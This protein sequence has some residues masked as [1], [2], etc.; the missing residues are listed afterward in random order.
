MEFDRE[1]ITDQRIG[2]VL[3][4]PP[5]RKN[6]GVW[7]HEAVRDAIEQLESKEVER[8]PEVERFNMRGA[9]SKGISEGGEQERELA[10]HYGKWAEVSVQWPCVNAM[11]MRISESWTLEAEQA[12][13]SAEMDA[14]RWCGRLLFIA[15]EILYAY[16]FHWDGYRNKALRPK[17]LSSR[18]K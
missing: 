12:N 2:A 13:L 9:Y 3:A 14:L 4:H 18:I 7:P 17:I 5:Q 11:L 16:T 6:D 8:G 15:R 10:S 1:K